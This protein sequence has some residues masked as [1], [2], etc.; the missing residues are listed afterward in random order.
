M[1]FETPPDDAVVYGR[2]GPAAKA[3]FTEF[4][5]MIQERQAEWA[6]WPRTYRGS[7]VQAVLSAAKVRDIDVD[8]LEIK[9]A[10]RDDQE[11]VWVRYE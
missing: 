6:R 9:Y 2:K 11:V 7:A 3:E 8:R 5:E 1:S 4:F 10:I